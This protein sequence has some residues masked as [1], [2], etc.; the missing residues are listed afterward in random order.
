MTDSGCP[1]ARP[2]APRM[3]PAC[4]IHPACQ[5]GPAWRIARGCRIGLLSLLCLL[6]SG[7]GGGGEYPSQPISLIC[8]W[9]A[10]GGTDRVSRQVAS[11]LERELGVPVNVINATGGSGVTGHTRGAVARPDGYTL[12]MI[13]VELNMLHWRGLTSINHDDFTPLALLNR[14]SAALFVRRDSDWNHLNELEAAIRREPGRLKASGT[15]YGG[16][17]HVAL[18]GWLDARGLDASAARWISINGAGPSMQELIAGGVDLVC[19]SLPEAE[20]LLSAGEVRCLG[21]MAPRRLASFPDVPTFREQG[22]DWAIAGWR[23]LAAPR[24]LPPQRLA[25]LAAAVRSVVESDELRRFMDDAGFQMEIE[26]AS[27]FAE[28]L[29]TQDELFRGI[30][31]G[32]AFRDIRDEHFGVMLFPAAIALAVLIVGLIARFRSGSERSRRGFPDSPPFRRASGVDADGA[33]R[34]DWRPP[35]AVLIA[36]TGYLLASE[37]LG[38]LPTAALALGGMLWAFRVRPWVAATIAVTASLATYQLFAV[39]LRVPLPRGFWGG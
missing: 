35:S 20:S 5:I 39:A 13:T 29:R 11:Q 36:C 18:A 25:V 1:A 9:S 32:E 38:F 24:G 19:C 28:T 12:T 8:P 2:V 26:D 37:S 15:A 31:T 14:D 4:Q 6:A 7:C 10:G 23:G 21:V 22:H 3:N 17:W 33:R 16:I 34:P 27:T 30:L